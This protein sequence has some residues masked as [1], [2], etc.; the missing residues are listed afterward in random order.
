[1]QRKNRRMS[2]VQISDISPYRVHKFVILLKPIKTPLQPSDL[3]LLPG[4]SLPGING[5][6]G[7][8][9]NERKIYT[10]WLIMPAF[11]SSPGCDQ[12][13]WPASFLL[14]L[15]NDFQKIG[16]ATI[17]TNLYFWKLSFK[18]TN[19]TEHAIVPQIGLKSA[20][21]KDEENSMS[22]TNI[23][24]LSKPFMYILYAK[25]LANY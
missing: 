13:T 9:N 20:I 3:A 21:P 12:K 22:K 1:M 10:S 14:P 5:S 7:I 19:S 8:I 17:H 4:P 2:G 23:S 6:D 25:T 15:P 18:K 11:L 16:K 24:S